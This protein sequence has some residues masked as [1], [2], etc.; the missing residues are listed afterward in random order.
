MTNTLVVLDDDAIFHKIM[1]Y[2]HAKSESYTH[3]YHDYQAG[4]LLVYLYE[5]RKEAERLPDV[6]FVDL[7]LPVLDGWA[8]LDGYNLLVHLLCKKINVYILTTSIRRQ[9]KLRANSYTFVE[10]YLTKPIATEKLKAIAR[11]ARARV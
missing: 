8:F 11:K 4:E 10:E 3:I 2:A 5:H 7:Y 1:D 6:I 9:D